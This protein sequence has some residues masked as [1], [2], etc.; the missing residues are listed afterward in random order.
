MLISTSISEVI[1]RGEV[2]KGRWRRNEMARKGGRKSMRLFPTSS[3]VVSPRSAW[4]GYSELYLSLPPSLSLSTMVDSE[5]PENTT[6]A[7]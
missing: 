4:L 7:F 6:P 3:L 2:K 1:A 5:C